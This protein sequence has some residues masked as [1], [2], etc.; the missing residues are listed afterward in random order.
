[1]PA[2]GK[3]HALGQCHVDEVLAA[4]LAP[5]KNLWGWN[6]LGKKAVKKKLAL[7]L[8]DANRWTVFDEKTKWGD[9]HKHRGASPLLWD[10]VLPRG[11]LSDVARG[12]KID[13]AGV[14]LEE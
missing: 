11:F 14:L 3:G 1:M 10:E 8:A 13:P 2:I 7:S 12:G 6:L 9:G 4:I 5:P